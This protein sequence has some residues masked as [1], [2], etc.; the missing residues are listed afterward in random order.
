[1]LKMFK[2]PSSWAGF[3]LLIQGIFSIVASQ[4]ADPTAWGTVA[5]GMGAVF[6]PEQRNIPQ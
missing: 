1:M 6:L 2:E 5:A 4:G 3:G